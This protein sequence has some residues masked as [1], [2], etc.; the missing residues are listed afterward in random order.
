MLGV[1]TG[2]EGGLCRVVGP[3]QIEWEISKEYDAETPVQID[4]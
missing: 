4:L 3:I 2:N 1:K